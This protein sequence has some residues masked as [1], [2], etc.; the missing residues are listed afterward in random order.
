[1]ST[2]ISIVAAI[3]ACTG[4]ASLAWQVYKHFQDGPKLKIRV[5]L[6]TLKL[7]PNSCAERVTYISIANTGK[8]PTTIS[9]LQLLRFKSGFQRWLTLAPHKISHHFRSSPEYSAKILTPSAVERLP[10]ELTVGRILLGAAE[11]T[12]VRAQLK[13]PGKL[14]VAVHHAF[15]ERPSLQKINPPHE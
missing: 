7:Q 14:Y 6:D 15:S 2:E 12:K 5:Q 4:V 11:N 3:G 1:M 8:Q 13:K 9:Q 10:K